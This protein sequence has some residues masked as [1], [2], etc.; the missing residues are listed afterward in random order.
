MAIRSKL[1]KVLFALHKDINITYHLMEGEY[2]EFRAREDQIGRYIAGDIEWIFQTTPSY[3]YK[4]IEQEIRS[5]IEATGC[6]KKVYEAIKWD[7]IF[8]NLAI[9]ADFASALSQIE[10]GACLA[11]RLGWGFSDKDLRQLA[12]LHKENRFRKKIED[13]LTDAN[14]HTEANLLFE[15]KYD[16][17]LEGLED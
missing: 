17:L 2:S 9:R 14:F 4:D 1:S 13:M 11:A 5:K 7:S 15:Q 6:A 12:E 16:E 10:D 8:E 3:C